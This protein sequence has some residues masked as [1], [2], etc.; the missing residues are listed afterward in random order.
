MYEFLSVPDCWMQDDNTNAK[1]ASSPASG[2]G[3]A[4]TQPLVVSEVLFISH[5]ALVCVLL[6]TP[7][8]TAVALVV[9]LPHH[10]LSCCCCNL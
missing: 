6:N 7:P 3:P 4:R 9:T 5:D 8:S 2:L 10:P 1:A